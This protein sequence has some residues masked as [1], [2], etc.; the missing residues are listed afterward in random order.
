MDEAAGYSMPTRCSTISRPWACQLP[1]ALSRRRIWID[2]NSICGV[3][4]ASRLAIIRITPRCATTITASSGVDVVCCGLGGGRRV[5]DKLKHPMNSAL[6]AER[7]FAAALTFGIGEAGVEPVA[8]PACE[9]G[10]IA[11]FDLG[12]SQAFEASEINFDEF[13]NFDNWTR[14][15]RDD[16]RTLSRPPQ[17]TGDD[18]ASRASRSR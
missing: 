9:V 2:P 16:R 6:D 7:E 4:P 1:A 8:I 15:A 11:R 18:R 12:R 5:I 17:R 13:F 14:A 10:W 3:T